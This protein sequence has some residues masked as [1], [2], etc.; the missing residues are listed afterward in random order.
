[1]KQ[2]HNNMSHNDF[3]RHSMSLNVTS[4]HSMYLNVKNCRKMP[5]TVTICYKTGGGNIR[6]AG[7]IRPA[8]TNFCSIEI[9]FIT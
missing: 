8:R 1:M 3:E 4:C 5:Q 7:Y 9:A 2:Y 6:P